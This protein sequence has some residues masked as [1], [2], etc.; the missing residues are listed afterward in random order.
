MRTQVHKREINPSAQQTLHTRLFVILL[1]CLGLSPALFAQTSPQTFT[2]TGDVQ[3]FTVP[4]GVTTL[5]VVANGAQGEGVQNS[6]LS[7]PIPT[8]YPG[9]K[10]GRVAATLTVTPGQN[11][12]LYVGGIPFNGGGNG[13]FS[14]GGGAT[15]IRIGGSDLSNRVLVAGGGGGAGNVREGGVGGGLIG[16]VG[17]GYNDSGGG[18]GGGTQSAGGKGGDSDG[19]VTQ[20]EDGKLGLG[21][22][23]NSSGG[24]SGGGGYYGG[25]GGQ[26]YYQGGGEFNASSGGGG[27]SYPDPANLPLNGVTSVVHE[28]GVNEGTGSITLSWVAAPPSATVC[29]SGA[30]GDCS[31]ANGTYVETTSFPTLPIPETIKRALQNT[32]T[33]VYMVYGSLGNLSAWI[34][35]DTENEYFYQDGEDVNTIPESNWN[36][37]DCNSDIT[38]TTGACQAPGIDCGQPQL[39]RATSM[40]V[41]SPLGP[42]NCSVTLKG[43]GYGTG[44][45]FTGPGGYVFSA[46]YRQVGSYAINGLNVTQPGTYT[47][48][49]TYSDACGQSTSDTMTYLVTGSACR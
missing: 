47:L 9:G 10:G 26:Y 6:Q 20:P 13:S 29:I 44:Y 7:I 3:T 16:G 30:T 36:T 22:K 32:T 21:G 33:G 1:I 34:I 39:A 40:T 43:T 46:V 19:G 12:S 42:N 17:G 27:S 2:Y 8:F 38:V 37:L 48:K 23:G 45:T 31:V 41:S 11:L 49:V 25:G 4:A 15:D 14:K 35:R 24:G 28:Q 5:S 18:G